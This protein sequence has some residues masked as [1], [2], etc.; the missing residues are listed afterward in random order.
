MSKFL[1]TIL[2][3]ITSPLLLFSQYYQ[4]A[5]IQEFM[6]R[7]NIEKIGNW[8]KQNDIVGSP[9]ASDDFEKGYFVTKTKYKISDVFL[10]FNIYNNN[11]EYK[12]EN[13]DVYALEIPEL[14]DF[15]VIGEIKYQYFPYSVNKKVH[16]GFFAVLE[17]GN[18]LL[19]RK[20]R[21]MYKKATEPGAYKDAE[22]AKFVRQTGEFF[23]KVGEREARYVGGKKDLIEILS[24]DVEGFIK[25]N[26]IKAGKEGH[27]RKLVQYYNSL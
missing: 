19:L 24:A 10:R 12:D 25:K 3:L 9:Y 15:V 21:V 14:F 2:F 1:F 23:I 6:T 4:N 11:I 16:K 13:G 18:T 27:L 26:K 17:E 5:T 8:N 22:P 20:D 7:K